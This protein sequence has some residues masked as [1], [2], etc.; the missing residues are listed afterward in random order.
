MKVYSGFKQY[1]RLACGLMVF[2]LMLVSEAV[3]AQSP[4]GSIGAVAKQ[5]V[6]SF[7]DLAKLITAVSYVAG[8]GFAIG[9]IMKFK[10]HKDNPTQ[11]PIGTPI[12]LIFIAAALI[13]LPT[14]FK[15]AGDT[16]FGTGTTELVGGTSGVA[17]FGVK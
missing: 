16:L 15:V 17:T 9:A 13:F 1:S 5:V 8:M 11:V 2:G 6:A 12:A 3:F 10:M 14:I 4:S 7:Q